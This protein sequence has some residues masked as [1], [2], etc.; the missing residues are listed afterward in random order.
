MVFFIVVAFVVLIGVPAV[1]PQAVKMNSG[2]K[3]N[4]QPN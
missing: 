4:K 2:S 3:K 1:C